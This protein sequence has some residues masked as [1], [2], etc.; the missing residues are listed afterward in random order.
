M[1]D[2]IVSEI[3]RYRD[4]HA[5]KFNYDIQAICADLIKKQGRHGHAVV[6]LAPHR[7]STATLL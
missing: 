6:K 4:N 1:N 2:P 5:K 7:M 3:R